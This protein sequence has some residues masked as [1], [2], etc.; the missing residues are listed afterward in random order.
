LL[1]DDHPDLAL[2]EATTKDVQILAQLLAYTY[3]WLGHGLTSGIS[4][5]GKSI[6]PG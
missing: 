3:N 5:L 4:I 1:N 6:I 2:A